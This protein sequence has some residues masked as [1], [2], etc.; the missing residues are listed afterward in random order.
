MNQNDI[1]VFHFS[2]NTLFKHIFKF[3]SAGDF[4]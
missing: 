2:E 1:L 4:F 3:L